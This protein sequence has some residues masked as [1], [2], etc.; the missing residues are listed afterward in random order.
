MRKKVAFIGVGNMA[1]AIIGGMISGGFDASDIILYDRH[2]EKM[3]P[4]AM[5]G[6]IVASSIE[7]AAI[8]ADCIMICVKP[9]G[10]GD[11][12]PLLASCENAKEKLYITIAAGITTQA[13]STAIGGASVVRALPNTP[14]LIGRGVTAI[15]RGDDISDQDF[16]F[17]CSLFEPSSSV[18]K[19]NENQMNK[20]ICVTSSSPAYMFLIIKSMLD[21]AASQDLLKDSDNPDGLDEKTLINCICDTMVGSAYLMKEGT[22]TPDEQIKTVASKGGTTE[23]AIA[24]LIEYKLPEA[25]VSAMQK[26]TDRAEE[27]GKK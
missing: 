10:F 8:L 1:T 24:E 17:A 3:Q 7:Q 5:R 14:I 11:V 16:E 19:I 2:I 9:Q 23:R 15:C 25:F 13:V 18:L 26:C 22:K 21:A 20:I 27:L 12:L 6:A 4:F